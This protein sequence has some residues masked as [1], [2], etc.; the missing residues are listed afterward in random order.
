MH[1]IASAA[2]AAPAEPGVYFFLADDRELLYVGKAANLR[3]RLQQHA[4]SVAGGGT[5]RMSLWR[6]SIA[7]ARW[8]T[9]ADEEAAAGREADLIVSFRPL[10]NRSLTTE[11]RWVYIATAAGSAT[12]DV[13]LVLTATPA[14]STA[15]AAG[16]ARSARLY[17]CF[18]HL[19]TGV[20]SRRAIACSE[21]YAALVRLLWAAGDEED[22]AAYPAAIVGPSP[23]VDVV[24]PFGDDL[25]TELHRLL[26]GQSPRLLD[27]LAELA[28]RRRPPVMLPA[29]RRDHASAAAFFHQGPR[30]LRALRRRHALPAQPISRETIE[31]LLEAEL[32]ATMGDFRLPVLDD[33]TAGVLGARASRAHA[34]K[35]ALRRRR[36]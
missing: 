25:A 27:R 24:V 5:A 36:T 31:S 26:S 12:R 7:E 33:P 9:C 21:G 19:G 20:S 1:P 22:R 8:D 32:R 29:L 30:E 28:G 13:R 18:P 10:F 17:G 14:A 15:A 6:S 11:G 3:S 16:A 4:R 2:A 35:A 23:P 34:T